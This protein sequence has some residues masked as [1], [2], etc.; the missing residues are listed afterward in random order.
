MTKIEHSAFAWKSSLTSVI[1]PDTVRSIGPDAFLSCRGLTA[2]TIPDSVTGIGHYAFSECT[3]LT[4][5]RIP[6]SVTGIGYC[7][8]SDCTGLTD[9]MLSEGIRKIDTE[10]FSN[11]PGLTCLR[12]PASVTDIG[13]NV[14]ASCGGLIV[15]IC[16][17]LYAV[18][19]VIEDGGPWPVYVGGPPVRSARG[20]EGTRLPQA[21]F[22]P[23]NRISARSTGGE[24]TIRTISGTMHGCWSWTM[25]GTGPSFGS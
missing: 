21:S 1:I 23:G 11:C 24:K 8:F 6:G 4:R 10:A 7:A 19:C 22:T 12:I 9:L 25:T 5:I 3:G 18:S 20:G 13:R 15:V 2:L 16:L 17:T 14:F